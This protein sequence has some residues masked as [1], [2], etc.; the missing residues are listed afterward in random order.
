MLR[1]SL[2]IKLFHLMTDDY[3]SGFASRL[4]DQ[5]WENIFV[6]IPILIINDKRLQC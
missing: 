5:S 4:N 1:N 2:E 6:L 3:K